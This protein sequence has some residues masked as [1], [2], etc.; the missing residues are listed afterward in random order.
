MALSSDDVWAIGYSRPTGGVS[1]PLM[2]HWDGAQW[3]RVASPNTNAS[4]KISEVTAVASNDIWVVG[5]SYSVT[6]APHTSTLIEH[7]DGIQWSIVPSPSP[8]AD[9]NFLDG[10]VAISASDIWAVGSSPPTGTTGP[11]APLTLHWD[12]TAWAQVPSPTPDP[13]HSSGLLNVAAVS[14]DNVWAVG[15]SY[16]GDVTRTLSMHWDGS[17][18]SIVPT[19]NVGTGSN[20]IGGIAVVSANDIWAVGVYDGAV[21]ETRTLSMHW[22]GNQWSIVPS[23]N[24][25]SSYNGLSDVVFDHNGAIWAV[26]DYV[27]FNSQTLIMRYPG[28]CTAITPSPTASLPTPSPTPTCVRTWDIVP[29]PNDTGSGNY[30]YN[31]AVVAPNDVWAVGA[32]ETSRLQEYR[33][34]TMHWDG[35]TWQL[36]P[37]S[38]PGLDNRLN[39]VAVTPS[40]EVWAVGY[41]TTDEQVSQTLM[42]H[43]KGAA[44]EQVAGPSTSVSAYLNE[45][46]ALSNDDIWAVG[47]LYSVNPAPHTLTF[48]QHWD[49]SQWSIVASP[50]PSADSNI[51]HGVA[52]ISANDVW[53]V[54]YYRS[55]SK[56]GEGLPLTLHWDGVTWTQVLT[57][58]PSPIYGSS[59]SSIAAVSSND[60]WAVG[61]LFEG[62]VSRTLSMHWDGSQWSIVPTPNVS[63]MNNSIWGI[64]IVSANDIWAVGV[65]DGEEVVETRTLTMHWDGSQWNIVPSP[66]PTSSRNRLNDVASDHNGIIWAVGNYIPFNSQTL[67]LRYPG[68]CVTPTPTSATPVPTVP[69]TPTITPTFTFVPLTSTPVPVTSTTTKVATAIASITAIATPTQCSLSFTDVPTTSTF[70]ANI[71]CLACRGILGGYSDGTFRPNNDITRG[72]I[73]KVVSNAAGF[74]DDPGT[75][76]YEDVPPTNTFYAWVNRLSKRGLMGGYPCGAMP[77][78]SCGTANRPYF[79]PN[80][81]A[82]R[83]QLAKIVASAAYLTTTPTGQRYADVEEDSTFYVWIE[84]LSSLGVMGG[85]TCGS[86]PTEPCDEEG[87]AYFRPSNN[88]TRGQASKIVANTFLPNC[89]AP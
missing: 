38:N 60:V 11:S 40:G 24:P 51:L 33:T 5:Y 48:I 36:V 85:Y 20:S 35:T 47:F 41:Y 75:Q 32:R 22:D 52:A 61:R 43:W 27:P 18:W 81:S 58:T 17:Q 3:N 23:P 26:G 66:S 80:A 46:T 70:Y 62:E 56:S 64:A 28:A 34:V 86:V 44:W 49:G 1:Q 57:P 63:T 31:V 89:Q 30:L 54:G 77:S 15:Y 73:A 65:Y 16:E 6:P 7:W 10:V 87:R 83:G 19:P 69:T 71:R 74:N 21:T 76:I 45:V 42:L 25:S 4:S 14:P 39:G 59:L 53:A 84:Q 78:E 88:V 68:G 29:S 9:Y 13:T 12:G 37:S 8:G 2:L 72:Q 50:S 67:V 79:R 55:S 82:T